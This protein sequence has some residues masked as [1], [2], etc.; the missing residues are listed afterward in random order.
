[1]KPWLFDILACPICK[2]FPL[3][4]FIFSFET[5]PDE[6]QNAISIYEKRDLEYIKNEKVIE[7]IEEN[8]DKFIRDEIVIE[9]TSLDNY[10][11]LTLSGIEELNNI[12]DKSGNEFSKK[13]IATI[14]KEIKDRIAE[15]SKNPDIKDIDNILPELYFINKIKIETEI[16]SGLFLC[17]GDGCNRWYPIIETIPMLLPDDARERYKEK[18]IEFLKTNKNLFEDEFFNKELKPYNI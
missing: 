11:K 6:F 7:I 2:N 12:V 8:G 4:L 18:E 15:F 5:E 1:M 13:S 14:T 9:K 16:E 3:K 17:E 10:L